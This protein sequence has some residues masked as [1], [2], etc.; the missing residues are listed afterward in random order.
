MPMRP[1]HSRLVPQPFLRVK[2]PAL[3]VSER[4]KPPWPQSQVTALALLEMPPAHYRRLAPPDSLPHSAQPCLNLPDP[5]PFVLRRATLAGRK[6]NHAE[7]SGAHPILVEATDP[8]R[9][10]GR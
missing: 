9:A 2:L 4:E 10:R 8:H 1:V 3:P 6:R 5:D 7:R